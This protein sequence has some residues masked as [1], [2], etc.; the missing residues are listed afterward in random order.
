LNA[1]VARARIIFG[2]ESIDAAKQRVLALISE[3]P[4]YQKQFER[5]IRGQHAPTVIEAKLSHD[6]AYYRYFDSI[7]GLAELAPNLRTLIGD[8]K[9]IS[10]NATHAAIEEYLRSL[11]NKYSASSH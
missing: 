3:Y 5:Q 2:Q 11:R 9:A 4:A 6:L 10:V 1:L 7:A 8:L